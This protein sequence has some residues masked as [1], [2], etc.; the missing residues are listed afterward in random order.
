MAAKILRWL[1]TLLLL[2]AAALW[3]ARG[4]NRGWTKNRVP[5]RYT[6][7]V[8]GI[9]GISYQN[10]FVPGMDFLGGTFLASALLTGVSFFLARKNVP[11]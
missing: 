6:D 11:T 2:G 9:E 5:S 4:A 3:L 8:T 1:A 10:R 7:P